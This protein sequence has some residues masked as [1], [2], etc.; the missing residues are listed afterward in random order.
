MCA[1]GTPTANYSSALGNALQTGAIL[2][3]SKSS[4]KIKQ[5]QFVG[6]FKTSR[7]EASIPVNAE[8]DV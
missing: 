8:G 4:G 3:N 1:G 7:F 2:R 6:Q 5:Q